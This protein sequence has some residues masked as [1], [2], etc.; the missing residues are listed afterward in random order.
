MTWVKI[1]TLKPLR[2]RWTHKKSPHQTKKGPGR[3]HRHGDSWPGTKLARA[4]AKNG[5]GGRS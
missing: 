4:I 2:R 3:Y 1:P 5:K